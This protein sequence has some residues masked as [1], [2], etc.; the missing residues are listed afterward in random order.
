MKDIIKRLSKGGVKDFY[1]G[2]SAYCLVHLFVGIMVI[3]SS[4]STGMF[5]K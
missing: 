1:S 2:F 5:E 3:E 4:L